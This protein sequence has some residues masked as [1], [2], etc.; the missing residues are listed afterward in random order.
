MERVLDRRNFYPN[1]RGP[2]PKQFREQGR[3]VFLELELYLE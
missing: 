3:T 1:L 2:D